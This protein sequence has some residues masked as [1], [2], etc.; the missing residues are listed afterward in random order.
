MSLPFVSDHALL[1]YLERARGIDVELIRGHIALLCAPAA[2]AGARNYRA[3]DGV[4]YVFKK[5]HVVTVMG[6]DMRPGHREVAR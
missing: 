1:R 6:A 4:T 2:A 3:A 5:G